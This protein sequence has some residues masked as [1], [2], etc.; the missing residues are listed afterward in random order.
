MEETRIV[1]LWFPTIKIT[2]LRKTALKYCILL[3]FL[4]FGFALPYTYYAFSDERS[5][6][7]QIFKVKYPTPL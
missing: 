1:S 4:G 7:E 5:E 3:S 6:E 2:E